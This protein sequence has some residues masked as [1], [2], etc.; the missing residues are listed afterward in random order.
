MSVSEKEP[1]DS[2]R[3]RN[4]WLII[5]A[6]L[7]VVI[8]LSWFFYWLLVGQYDVYTED[9]YI[10][11]NEVMLTP[12]V[13]SGVQT[14]Y[15]DET[16]FVEEGE[17]IVELDNS[18]YLI[19]FE[20]L[21][22]QLANKVMEVSKL[23][24][25]V[26]ARQAEVDLKLAQLKQAELDFK[27]REPLVK[28]GAVSTE[29]FETY[30]TNVKVA[31]AAYLFA[32]KELAAAQSLIA[33]SDLKTHPIIQ[34]AAWNLREAYLNLI[35]CQIRAPVTGYVAKRTVQAGDQVKVGQI[36]LYIVPLDDIW[37]E[38]NYK[39]TQLKNVR[40]GQSVRFTADLYGKNVKYLGKIIGF[41]PG[42]GNAFSLLPPQN[43]SGNWIKIVQRIPVRI[44]IDPEQI[45]KNPLLLGLSMKVTVDVH[46][47]SGPQLALCPVRE[48]LYSTKIFIKQKEQMAHIESLI[49][50]IIQKNQYP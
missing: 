25:N 21:K 18:D 15:T 31:D 40:I 6:I 13:A 20:E 17:L 38:A 14:I 16:H 35:R 1:T 11:G 5:L 26:Q 39:E 19:R 3:K 32:Q 50:E 36:L 43:A 2:K 44:S 29:Q 37:I 45:R 4:L 8:G 12:Q 30:Q 48:P 9:A 23:F 28:T 24:Q 46:D 47:R 10:S 27:H 34:E 42:S 33:G 22:S 49:Q 7:F 41:Q